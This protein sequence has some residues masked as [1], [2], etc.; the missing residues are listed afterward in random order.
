MDFFLLHNIQ[1]LL[2]V[3]CLK[4]LISLRSQINPQCAD[5]IRLV[6]T[7]QNIVHRNASQQYKAEFFIIIA[8]KMSTG[9]G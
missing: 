9:K 2:A 8:E 1:S 7:N 3:G 5:D 6:I 4:Q